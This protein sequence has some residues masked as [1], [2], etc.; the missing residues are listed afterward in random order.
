M[1]D[2]LMKKRWNIVIA[3]LVMQLCLGTVY[4]WSVFKKPIM[5]AHG[6]SDTQSTL[7]FTIAI[8]VLGVS[9]AFGGR[10]VDRK[11]PKLV[12]TIAGMLFG[13]GILLSG[14]AES[15]GSLIGL[16]LTYGLIAGIG[17]G[18]GYVTPITIL[19]RWFPDKRGLITGLA[20]MGFGAGGSV[21]G[22]IAPILIES[23]GVPITF[24][25]FGAA[26]L[27]LVTGAAQF[28]SNP[29]EGWS[30]EGFTPA[31]HKA[32][33]GM[34]ADL[35][36]ALRM[37]QFY[38]LWSLLFLNVTAGIALISQ[39]SPMAQEAT[40]IS[41]VAAGTLILVMLIFNGLGRLFWAALSDKL[42]RKTVF[43]II[44]ASQVVVFAILPQ[45]TN[46]LV[47]AIIA[48]YILLCYGGGFGTMPAYTA[49]TFGTKHMGSIYGWILTAWS[50]A[51]VLGPMVM[52]YI[53]Q[54]TESFGPAL[55]MASGLL[56]LGFVLTLLYR[57][58]K[59][60]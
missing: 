57:K 4:T 20:V 5:A 25:V 49:D 19:V 2:P 22:Q 8:A 10:L 23:R 26:F 58:P 52:S 34:A 7:A 36:T 45:V 14:A 59:L 13:L 37:P 31:Q 9:A 40:K 1:A 28:Y 48:C 41:A 35:S 29:P 33:A 17:M 21:M 38:V 51:G 54:T 30:P 32:A 42:G 24:Y 3:A 43:L 44:F 50:A 55:Y 16:Y 12:A 39:A 56:A 15:L 11:G 18:F 27:I 47:F 60:S 46:I 53:R 6:W